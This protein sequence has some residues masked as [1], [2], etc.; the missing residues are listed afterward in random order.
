MLS[1][2]ATGTPARGPLSLPALIA[3]SAALA[4]ANAVSLSNVT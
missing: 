3:S 4:F 2:I 1:L